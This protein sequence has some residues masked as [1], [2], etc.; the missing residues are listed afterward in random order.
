ML[1]EKE[2]KRFNSKWKKI[3]DC[4]LWQGPLDRDGYGYI[5]LRHESQR[6]HRVAYFICHGAIP[7]GFVVNHTCRNRSCVNPQ[8]LNTM[9]A[10]ENSK[11][12]TTSRGYINSQKTRCPRGHLYDRQYG[13][14]RSCSKCDAEKSKRLRAK[15]KAEGRTIR[16]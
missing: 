11:R 12:D 7:D 3:G 15:W 4:H 5:T 13:G 10:S 1:T 2:I 6:A 9:S 14:Q 8:H 16:I